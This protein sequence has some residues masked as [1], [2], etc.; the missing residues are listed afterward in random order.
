MKNWWK[1]LTNFIAWIM[2][3]ILNKSI[4]SSLNSKRVGIL[5]WIKKSTG[6]IFRKILRK[7]R[8]IIETLSIKLRTYR[9]TKQIFKFIWIIAI[10]NEKD[11]YGTK[12]IKL[13][14][15]KW[16]ENFADLNIR[17]KWPFDIKR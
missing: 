17:L 13:N 6:K 2:F 7:R 3:L 8:I 5:I 9:L 11:F 16:N 15:K 14:S 1:G 4:K 10:R 12:L